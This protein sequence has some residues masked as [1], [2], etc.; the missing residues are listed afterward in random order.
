MPIGIKVEL[1]LLRDGKPVTV[2]VELQQSNQTQVDSSTIFNGIEGAEMSNKGQDKGVVVNNVKACAAGGTGGLR[3]RHRRGESAAGEKHR[4]S[5]ENLRRQTVRTGAEHSARRRLYLSAVAV[6]ASARFPAPSLAEGRGL[7]RSVTAPTTPH[8]SP[9]L[10][11]NAQCSATMT[12]LCWCPAKGRT[13]WLAGI[14]IPK[15]RR[16]LW[17][18]PCAS[19]IPIST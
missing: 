16:I 12:L 19:S 3:K 15:W 9:R 11:A 1:G 5:A 14:L 8:I 6:T 13:T 18:G 2:T 17:R 4:R 10:S 7:F